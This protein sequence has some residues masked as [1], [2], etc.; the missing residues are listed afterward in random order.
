MV[1]YCSRPSG[2]GVAQ[3]MFMYVELV[4]P[5]EAPGHLTLSVLVEHRPAHELGHEWH[6]WVKDPLH[7]DCAPACPTSPNPPSAAATAISTGSVA[8]GLRL[9]RP[10]GSIGTLQ[11]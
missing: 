6:T 3:E 4:L 2:E 9:A 7:N 8:V 11:P 1:G 5:Q 10:K